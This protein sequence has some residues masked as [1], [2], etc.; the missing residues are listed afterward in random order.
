M[1]LIRKLVP[2][3]PPLVMDDQLQHDDATVHVL[4]T[5]NISWSMCVCV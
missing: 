5:V 1:N 3:F 2:C 4:F